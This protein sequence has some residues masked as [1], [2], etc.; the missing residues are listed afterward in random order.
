MPNLEVTYSFHLIDSLEEFDKI[1]WTLHGQFQIKIPGQ[2]KY[3]IGLELAHSKICISLFQMKYCLGLLSDS[4]LFGSK[5]V[6]TLADPS[7]KLLNESSSLH[8]DIPCS[9]RLIGCLLYLTT[10]I[11]YIIFITQQLCQFLNKPSTTHFNVATRVLWY[12]KQCATQCLFFPRESSIHITYYF[13]VDWAGCLET[14]RSISDQC[15]FVIKS[16]NSRRTKKQTI[17]SVFPQ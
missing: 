13:D 6:I 5:H 12:L 7:I 3:F 15:F 14:R 9:K 2:L 1:K 17:V 8:M 10:I 4:G 11:Y 16:L